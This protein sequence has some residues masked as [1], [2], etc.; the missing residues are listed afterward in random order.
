MSQFRYSAQTG[1]YCDERT[2]FTLGQTL[3]LSFT[4]FHSSVLP[5]HG[6]TGVGWSDSWSE[7]A[8]VREQGNRVDII[9][10]GATL[11]FAFDGDSDTAVMRMTNPA[12]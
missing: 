3:P 9:S 4:R 5:L 12:G 7:Y 11:R 10:Q 2:D 6:L 8:W 1:A